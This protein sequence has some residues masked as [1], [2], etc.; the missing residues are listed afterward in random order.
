MRFRRIAAAL[1]FSSIAAKSQPPG[2]ACLP[3]HAKEVAG[4]AKTAMAHSI[5]RASAI[6]P[7]SYVHESSGTKFTIQNS[8]T[9]PRI[10]IQHRSLSATWKVA[11][12][13]G[14]GSHAYGL[15]VSVHD[16][17]FQAPVSYYAQSARWGVAPGFES[18]PALDFGRPVTAECLYCHADLPRPVSGTL[19]HYEN[20]PL[21][22]DAISCDRC[23]GDAT[24]HV[25]HPT[26]NNIVNPAALSDRARDSV[27]EQCHLNGEAR[28]LNPG[29]EWSDFKPGKELEEIYS[30]YVRADAD[31]VSLKVISHAEQLAMSRCARASGGTLWCGT[32]HDPHEQPAEPASYYR[33]RCLSCHSQSL[34]A[35]HPKLSNKN[36]CIAC[37]MPKRQTADGAHTVFTDHRITRRPAPPIE[38]GAVTKLRAWREP[39]PELRL[40]NLGLANIQAGIRRQSD[41]LIGDGANQIQDALEKNP[42]DVE[43]L[44]QLGVVLTRVRQTADAIKVLETAI[45]LS[46]DN[47]LAHLNLGDAYREAGVYAKAVVELNRAIELDPSLQDAYR[48]LEVTWLRSG[49]RPAARATIDRYLKFMPEGITG[50][51]ALDDAAKQ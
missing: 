7:G 25:Q 33:R 51:M 2:A 26:R 47:A 48:S 6:A 17:L 3:C 38:S 32:C 30:V 11:Y 23:H 4:Y 29:R 44:M 39:A 8:E 36:D 1:L 45:S 21:S 15:L 40:R 42:R 18:A 13:I 34:S 37:H 16:Y 20:P 46:P 31:R 50:R 22:G 49:N 19:N 9:G 10:G 12:V 5:S 28:V 27:C 24:A 35:A 14:S 41:A 43:M